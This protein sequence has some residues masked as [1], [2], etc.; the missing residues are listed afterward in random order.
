VIEPYYERDGITIFNADCRDV[1]PMLEHGAVMLTDPPYGMNY[2]SG[3]GG[4]F[5]ESRVAGDGS[6]ELR[7]AALALW[8]DHAALIFG[9]WRV[10]KPIATRAVLIWDSGS[11]GMGDLELP[12]RPSVQEIYVLGRGFTGRRGT[13]ILS[14]SGRRSGGC[15]SERL[16][17][18]EKPVGLLRDLLAKCPMGCVVD[19][20]M[21]SGSTLRAAMDLGRPAVGIETEERYCE[22][23][24]RRLEQSVLDLGGVA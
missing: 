5:G 17:P 11:W 24:A 23:A 9:T 3:W 1:L 10:Q 7:D 16:H 19:P 15:T 8:G 22:I 18:T 4:P 12:W 21:G 2:R 14:Y 6:A 20:F 13:P